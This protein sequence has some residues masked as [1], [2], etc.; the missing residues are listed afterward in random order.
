MFKHNSSADQSRSKLNGC[1]GPSDHQGA[2][3]LLSVPKKV[4]S[5]LLINKSSGEFQLRV[6]N[7]C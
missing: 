4:G 5:V 6:F 2:P 7:F 1:Y 3:I